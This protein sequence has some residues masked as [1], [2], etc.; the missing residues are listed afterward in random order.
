MLDMT[1]ASPVKVPMSVSF[2]HLNLLIFF[3]IAVFWNVIAVIVFGA[4]DK[5]DS[6]ATA[7]I[8]G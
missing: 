1:C 2:V 4:M 6:E 7:A 8:F 5:K 3:S